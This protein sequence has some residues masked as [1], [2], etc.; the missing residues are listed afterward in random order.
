MVEAQRALEQAQNSAREA[1]RA[2]ESQLQND[3]TEQ[4]ERGRRANEIFRQMGAPSGPSP[5]GEPGAFVARYGA[6]PAF[7]DVV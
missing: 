1:Q 4:Q 7:D 5:F 2:R 6:P 3:A